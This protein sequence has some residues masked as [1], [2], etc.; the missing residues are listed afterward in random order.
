V[1]VSLPL[2]VA[3]GVSLGV[4]VRL[5]E[6][7]GEVPLDSVGYVAVP[8]RRSRW[9]LLLDGVRRNIAR[10]IGGAAALVAVAVCL[11][12]CRMRRAARAAKKRVAHRGAAKG[13]G[14]NA[15]IV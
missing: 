5:G 11:C 8:V 12:L 6:I 14:A 3:L 4:A 10:A 2:E 13:V 15:S 7:D 9:A 1:G